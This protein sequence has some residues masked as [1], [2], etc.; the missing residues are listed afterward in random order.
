MTVPAGGAVAL[1]GESGC[2]KTT[3][4]RMATG[5]LRPDSGSV[6]WADGA[7]RPQ[8]VFQDAGSSLTPWLTI[9]DQIIERLRFAGVE[10][11]ERNDRAMDALARVGLDARAARARPRELSGGQRQR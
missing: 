4:L 2:G 10:R 3:A 9:A 6:T 11:R 1:V 8:M 7:A 5:L